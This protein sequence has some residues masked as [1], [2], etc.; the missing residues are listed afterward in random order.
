M[1]GMKGKGGYSQPNIRLKGATAQNLRKSAGGVPSKIG[2]GTIKEG[3]F[4]GGSRGSG[5]RG[6][7]GPKGEGFQGS[8]KGTRTRGTIPPKQTHMGFREQ[9]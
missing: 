6:K 3:G 7:V 5:S 8:L 1:K 9:A 4:K 2:G